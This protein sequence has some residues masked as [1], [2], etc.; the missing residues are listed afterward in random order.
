MTSIKIDDL[1]TSTELD[2]EAM[3]AVAGGMGMGPGM[4]S[5]QGGIFAPVGN[6]GGGF[7]FGSPTTIVSVPV[8]VPITLNL[9]LDTALDIDT[10]VANI[11]GS[12]FTGV[13]Q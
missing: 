2:S 4:A 11:V 12:A 5:M 9:D 8:N 1:E 13:L 7:S 6:V 10:D 3:I